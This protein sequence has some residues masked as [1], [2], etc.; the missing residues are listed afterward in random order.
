MNL[1]ENNARIIV[2]VNADEL[3]G[4]KSPCQIACADKAAVVPIGRVARH[5]SREG[6]FRPVGDGRRV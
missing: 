4:P 1:V 5:G 6:H 2:V 3:I